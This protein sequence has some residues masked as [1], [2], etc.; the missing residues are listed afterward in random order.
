[1]KTIATYLH[2]K[3]S[4][5][6]PIEIRTHDDDGHRERFFI[7]PEDARALAAY[8]IQGAEYVEAWRAWRKT[9]DCN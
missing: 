5:E 1:M 8:L 4:E 3:P 9:P 6:C 7:T 2:D